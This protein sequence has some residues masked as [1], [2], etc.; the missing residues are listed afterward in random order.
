MPLPLHQ[1]PGARPADILPKAEMFRLLAARC[2]NA[3][4]L[5]DVLRKLECNAIDADEKQDL[6]EQ[7][8]Q[9]AEFTATQYEIETGMWG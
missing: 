9:A 4:G 6:A 1:R 2:P 3:A 5:L 7:L 8:R